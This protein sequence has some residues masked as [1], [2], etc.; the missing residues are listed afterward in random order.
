MEATRQVSFQLVPKKATNKS[1]YNILVYEPQKVVSLPG[2]TIAHQGMM[3]TAFHIVVNC[4][5]C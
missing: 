1:N 5:S 2:E 3:C 4:C